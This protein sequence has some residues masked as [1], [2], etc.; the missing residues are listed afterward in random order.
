M[1]GWLLLAGIA[2]IPILIGYV[3]GFVAWVGGMSGSESIGGRI[4]WGVAP[5]LVGWIPLVGYV[6]FFVYLATVR[7]SGSSGSGNYGVDRYRASPQSSI[8]QSD[9]GAWS[10]P[11]Q[12][13]GTCYGNKVVPCWRCNG[14]RTVRGTNEYCS[15]CQGGFV[16][17]T[18]CH[19]TGT[20]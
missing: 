5:I 20:A 15:S 10:S 13:C 8:G 2:L 12:T 16:T 3:L 6:L 7:R 4:G 17:C 9:F 18:S 14:T 11:S 19:G 1:G